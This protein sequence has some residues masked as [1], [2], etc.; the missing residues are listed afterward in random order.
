MFAK[1]P[2][3]I[4]CNDAKGVI[5]R[6]MCDIPFQ[7]KE[8]DI[9]SSEDLYRRYHEDIP[10]IFINGKKAFKFKIDEVEF[11]RR[12]RKELIKDGIQRLCQKKQ[13]YS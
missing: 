2:D 11:K 4:L 7:F 1:H 5:N 10:T 12:L 13:H 9:C 6:V 3:C 8:V